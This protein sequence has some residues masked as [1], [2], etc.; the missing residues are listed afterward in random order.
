MDIN[1]LKNKAQDLVNNPKVQDA[2]N[3]G[4]DWIEN[5]QGKE[6]IEKGKEFIDTAKD[7]VENFVS[8]KTDG[9]GILGFGK[10]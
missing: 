10:K 1:E 7:K 3:K 9:K 8:D 6:Y 2:V 4:K 5:G